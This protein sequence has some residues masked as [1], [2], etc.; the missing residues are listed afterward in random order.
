MK[1]K[2][3]S[4]KRFFLTT[5]IPV[6][7]SLF[8]SLITLDCGYIIEHPQLKGEVWRIRP[9]IEIFYLSPLCF[10]FHCF[11]CLPKNYQPVIE[12]FFQMRTIQSWGLKNKKAQSVDLI[13]CIQIYF[14]S[15][16]HKSITYIPLLFM[17]ENNNMEHGQ[18][19]YSGK[20]NWSKISWE[21][22]W[23]KSRKKK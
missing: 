19:L 5:H 1:Y 10:Y 3:W 12:I 20:E 8:Q 2:I 4:E 22:K 23:V 6:F 16:W 15:K 14:W 17:S 13:I 7:I 9:W 18:T 21:K 11:G